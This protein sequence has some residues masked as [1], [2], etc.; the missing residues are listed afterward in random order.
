MISISPGH[1]V[2]YLTG[3]V[4]TGHENYYT[5]AVAA[6]EPP[7]FWS[8]R[9]AAALGLTGEVRWNRKTGAVTANVTLAGAVTGTLKLAWADDRP[10]TTATA[11]GKVDGTTVNGAFAAP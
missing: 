8:G 5:G 7:G 10:G 4:A 6:G 2:D 3:E 1:A 9:G 11:T